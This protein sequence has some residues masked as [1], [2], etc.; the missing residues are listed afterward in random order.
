MQAPTSIQESQPTELC[1]ARLFGLLVLTITIL[2]TK[3]YHPNMQTNRVELFFNLD[4]N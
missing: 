3:K 1:L 4:S 2:A